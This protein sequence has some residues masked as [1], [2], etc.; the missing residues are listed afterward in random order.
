MVIL[1]DSDISKGA[2]DKSCYFE[3]N[4]TIPNTSLVYKAVQK[5]SVYD[6]GCLVTTDTTGGCRIALL[7][8]WK[9]IYKE[10]PPLRT[11]KEKHS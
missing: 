1:E 5:F 10:I 3:M 7:R 11:M 2:W 9:Y 6:V 4:F 8:A